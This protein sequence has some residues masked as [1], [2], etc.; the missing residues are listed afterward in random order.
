[1]KAT[2]ESTTRM[3]IVNGMNFR[4]WE[5]V[6]EKGIPFVALVNRL[7][8]ADPTVQTAL[9]TETMA[10]QKEPESTTQGAL[11]RLGVGAPPAP[12]VP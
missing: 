11:D 12:I 2:M 6:S 9:I 1:M 5:G 7:E 3:L 10:K 4:V 8:S